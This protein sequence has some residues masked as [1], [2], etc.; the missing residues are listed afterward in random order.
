MENINRKE[1]TRQVNIECLRLLLMFMVVILH[2]F[3]HSI[4]NSPMPQGLNADDAI[5]TNN[6]YVSY[7]I[8]GL[9]I[10][11]VDC[12]ILISGFF[13]I[14]FSVHKL[15]KL[16]LLM[17]EYRL[18]IYLLFVITGIIPF[19]ISDL[20]KYAVP[21]QWWFMQYYIFLMLAS[22]LLNW[23]TSN[24]SQRGYQFLLIEMF[25][26][27]TIIPTISRFSFT[28]DRGQ[29]CINFIFMYLLGSYI[30]KYPYNK[31]I[32][33]RWLVLFYILNS[34]I[35][36]IGNI[37]LNKGLINSQGW[38]SQLWGY[39]TLLVQLN[40]V[41]LFFA[42]KN[43]HFDNRKKSAKFI[44]QCAK[45]TLAIYIIHE[46]VLVRDMLF[47]EILPLG[48][49]YS[50]AYFI[51]IALIIGIAIYVICM[52]IEFIRHKLLNRLENLLLNKIL[53]NKK[54]SKVLGKWA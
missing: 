19:S 9:C 48:S 5:T 36:L 7:F 38:T 54:L 26:I 12:F 30:R 18:G 49:L 37:I 31:A 24:I 17:I 34:I 28:N 42:F 43:L 20:I 23:I 46:H 45:C 6:L 52:A 32:K 1:N 53:R 13:S 50:S 11:A 22:P 3:G 39:D 35:M 8:E 47:G 41:L 29:G 10:A 33:S 15:C 44:Q 21:L 14:K 4:L 16:L 2:V 40:A 25:F 51:P 27:F